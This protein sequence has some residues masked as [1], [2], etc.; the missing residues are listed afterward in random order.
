MQMAGGN[1]TAQY[2]VQIWNVISRITRW[3]A[4]AF[5]F[6]EA[7]AFRRVGG[8][9][10]ELYISEEIDLNQRLHKLGRE[11]GRGMVIIRR[12]PLLTSGRKLELY[13]PVEILAFMAKVVIRPRRTMK[14]RAACE[15]WYDGR[16]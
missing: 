9:N 3:A 7:N 11:T 2:G 13:S 10:L 16:R 14:T 6:C 12:P 4:G 1:V 5:I 15:P 8:F